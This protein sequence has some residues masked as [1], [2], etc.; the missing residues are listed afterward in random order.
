MSW[1]FIFAAFILA[2]GAGITGTYLLLRPRIIATQEL[3]AKTA[4]Q[5]AE[6]RSEN[7]RL[8]EESSSLENINLRLR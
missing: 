4:A 6:I 3:D 8:L 7:I 5:N 1:I 2:L